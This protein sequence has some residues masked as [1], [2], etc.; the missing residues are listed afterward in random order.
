MLYNNYRFFI[1][2]YEA[3]PMPPFS[4]VTAGQGCEVGC[5]S[6][7]SNNF[8]ESQQVLGHF[9]NALVVEVNGA[10]SIKAEI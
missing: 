10:E 3:I 9:S 2:T 1:Q 8:K 6:F 5:I 4:N 7:K